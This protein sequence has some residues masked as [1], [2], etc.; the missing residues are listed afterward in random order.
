MDSFIDM[1]VLAFEASV[2]T[3]VTG[4]ESFE[5]FL[6]VDEVVREGVGLPGTHPEWEERE[7]HRVW[8]RLCPLWDV[9]IPVVAWHD[10]RTYRLVVTVPAWD[11]DDAIVWAHYYCPQVNGDFLSDQATAVVAR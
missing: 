1:V 4:S 9:T 11:E 8:A 2:A 10:D 5:Y 6:A 7:V 3:R